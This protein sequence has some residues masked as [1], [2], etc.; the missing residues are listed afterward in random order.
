MIESTQSSTYSEAGPEFALN[1][2]STNFNHTLISSEKF[3][4]WAA[5]FEGGEYYVTSVRIMNR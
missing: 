1:D 3:E 2:D 5:N 4:H